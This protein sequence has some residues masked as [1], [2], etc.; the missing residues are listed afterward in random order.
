M[1]GEM[2]RKRAV[3]TGP[4]WKKLDFD[5]GELLIDRP[6]LDLLGKALVKAVIHEAKKDFAKRRKMGRGKPISDGGAIGPEKSFFRSFSYQIRGE[7]TIELVSNW[8]RLDS[9]LE[10][11]KKGKMTS[12]TAEK[13]PKLWRPAKS[14]KGAKVRKTIPIIDHGKVIFRTVPLTMADAWIHPGISKH[15]FMERGVRRWKKEAGA[16]IATWLAGRG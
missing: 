14:G 8:P 4:L 9:L 6:L 12:L 1:A 11:R 3:Y 5:K 15:T 7:R 13:N 2:R 10:G 16:I